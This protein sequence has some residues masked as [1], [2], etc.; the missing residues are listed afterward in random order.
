MSLKDKNSGFFEL[1]N[2][3]IGKT[4]FMDINI[5][6]DRSCRSIK[7]FDKVIKWHNKFYHED[8]C[9]EENSGG[10]GTN[11]SHSRSEGSMMLETPKFKKPI[12]LFGVEGENVKKDFVFGD[13]EEVAPEP[14]KKKKVEEPAIPKIKQKKDHKVREY[15]EFEEIK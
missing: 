3:R 2:V 8:Y 5:L 7:G 4:L 11:K 12:K 13:M 14:R 1:Q 15:I 10:Q 9:E 6:C